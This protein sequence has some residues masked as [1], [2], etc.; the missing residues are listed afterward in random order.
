MSNNFIDVHGTFTVDD[1]ER[2]L[3]LLNNTGSCSLRLPIHL[4]QGGGNNL[5]MALNQFV[6]TWARKSIDPVLLTHITPND[7]YRHSQLSRMCSRTFGISAM[8]MADMIYCTDGM[9]KISKREALT[10][11]VDR[12][13]SI[14]SLKFKEAVSRNGIDLLCIM[15]SGTM[16]Y[17]EPFY[18]IPSRGEL[19][20]RDQYSLLVEEIIKIIVQGSDEIRKRIRNNS[21][22][23]LGNILYEL[24]QNTDEHSL[25]DIDGIQ[26]LSGTRGLPLEFIK[27]QRV[28]AHNS[29]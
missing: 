24:V 17:I 5:D 14:N 12:L 1:L 13:K 2:W 7:P 26:Y 22:S 18:K 28:S 21:T 16:K 6:I 4:P 15:N 27:T 10:P 9:T 29:K 8:T 19:R 23:H 11:A 25:T 3:K 20:S